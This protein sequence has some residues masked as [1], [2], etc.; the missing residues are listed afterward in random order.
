MLGAQSTISTT[1]KDH[2]GITSQGMH[3]SATILLLISSTAVVPICLQQA[4]K[5]K[6]PKVAIPTVKRSKQKC[7][8]MKGKG[9]H[10]NG[11]S[12]LTRSLGTIKAVFVEQL[13]YCPTQYWLIPLPTRQWTIQTHSHRSIPNA[14]TRGGDALL[15]A[16]A[17]LFRLICKCLECVIIRGKLI[18]TSF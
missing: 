8:N 6:M 13:A 9:I 4:N 12:R 16:A 18:K 1:E 10:A 17:L 2:L 11:C 5:N 3:N 14:H 7:P 15:N